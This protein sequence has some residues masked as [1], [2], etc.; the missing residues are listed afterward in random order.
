MTMFC[1]YEPEAVKAIIPIAN[2]TSPYFVQNLAYLS[3]TLEASCINNAHPSK[4][5]SR[6][7]CF[8]DIPFTE[9]FEEVNENNVDNEKYYLLIRNGNKAR[10]GKI[11][12]FGDKLNEFH[13]LYQLKYDHINLQ[14]D[15]TLVKYKDVDEFDYIEPLCNMF[16]YTMRFYYDEWKNPEKVIIKFVPCDIVDG[17]T[18][19]NLH[20]LLTLN[21]NEVCD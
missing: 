15:L 17:K 10:S 18:I 11:N 14:R 7:E 19:I 1:R 5:I 8:K 12:E 4:V 21:Y 6:C 16:R 20:A 13:K 9:L 3:W 2:P